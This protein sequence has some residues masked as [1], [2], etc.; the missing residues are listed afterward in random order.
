MSDQATLRA[1]WKQASVDG[2]I[3]CPDCGIL[4]EPCTERCKGCGWI[5]PLHELGLA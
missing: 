2:T 3:D 1:L 5:N 4:L